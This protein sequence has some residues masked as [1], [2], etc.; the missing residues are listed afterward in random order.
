MDHRQHRSKAIH[1]ILVSAATATFA[2]SGAACS[3]G[4]EEEDSVYC[5][6]ENGQVVDDHYCDNNRPHRGSMHGYY[7]WHRS[8]RYIYSRGDYVSGG[9]RVRTDD[10]AGR[11]RIGVSRH[12]PVNSGVV[13]RGGVGK[14]SGSGTSGRGSGS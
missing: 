3:S 7:L 8:G 13:T 4:R 5:V 12:G 1:L 11:A 9:E 14:G 2:L 10:A 6:D